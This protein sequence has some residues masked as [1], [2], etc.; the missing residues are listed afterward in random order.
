M[1][2]NFTVD[3]PQAQ[4]VVPCHGPPVLWVLTDGDAEVGSRGIDNGAG[5]PLRQHKAVRCRMIW[6]RR[7]IP[8]VVIHQERHQVCQACRRRGVT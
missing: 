7:I 6:I 5:V 4:R 3:S 1:T 2:I 8:H